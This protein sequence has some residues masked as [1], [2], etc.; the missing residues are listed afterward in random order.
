M[1]KEFEEASDE[2]DDEDEFLDDSEYDEIQDS[3]GEE[4]AVHERNF[5][6]SHLHPS[7]SQTLGD[8]DNED[9]YR[10]DEDEYNS[11]YEDAADQLEEELYFETVLDNV[12]FVATSKQTVA[13]L[14][15]E[16]L[17][18]LS[19]EQRQFLHTIA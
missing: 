14:K 12:D 10:D 15:P 9:G 1:Q 19:M 4:E 2:E 13:L 16:L 11:D 6:K 18:N 8:E 5:L 3:D 17:S 7:S